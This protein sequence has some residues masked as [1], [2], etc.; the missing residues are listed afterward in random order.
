MGKWRSIWLTE[1]RCTNQIKAKILIKHGI[2]FKYIKQEFVATTG[3]RSKEDFHPYFGLRSIVYNPLHKIPRVV[4]IIDLLDKNMDLWNLLTAF[5][6]SN[7]KLIG[8]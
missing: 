2:T 4:L 1:L 7:S 5:H 3:L 6:S 8:R